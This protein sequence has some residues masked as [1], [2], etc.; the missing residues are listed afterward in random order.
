MKGVKQ[1][2][3][4]TKESFLEKETDLELVNSFNFDILLYDTMEKHRFVWYMFQQ[5]NYFQTFQ[6]D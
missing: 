6:I 1:M 2:L 4:L 5:K 3:L